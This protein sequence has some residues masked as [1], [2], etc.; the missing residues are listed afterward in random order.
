MPR[1]SGVILFDEEQPRRPLGVEF[2][3]KLFSCMVTGLVMP[4]KFIKNLV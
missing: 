3:G 2:Q 4:T 1:V